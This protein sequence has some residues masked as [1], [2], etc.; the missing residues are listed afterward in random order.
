M[1][2]EFHP[3]FF[4]LSLSLSS[5]VQEN[6]LSSKWFSFD[7]LLC[8][9]EQTAVGVEQQPDKDGAG[10]EG[11]VQAAPGVGIGALLL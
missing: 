6:L 9:G 5:S 10:G 3:F 1:N 7:H 11:A 8:F 2:S 4:S